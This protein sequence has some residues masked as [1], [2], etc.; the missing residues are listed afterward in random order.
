M[1]PNRTYR[2]LVQVRGDR[3]RCHRDDVL[4]YDVR[5]G[6]LERGAVGFRCWGAVVRLGAIRVTAPDGRVLWEGPPDVP[7]PR[8]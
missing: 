1:A 3:F 5:D 7:G 8:T 2:V 4:I 6:R